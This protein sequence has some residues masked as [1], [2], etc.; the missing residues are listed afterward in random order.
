MIQ[1]DP[2]WEGE[3]P[4]LGP[5]ECGIATVEQQRVSDMRASQGMRRGSVLTLLLSSIVVP[6]SANSN[7]VYS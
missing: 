7:S 2:R 1:T 6:S 3:E 4:H 5:E